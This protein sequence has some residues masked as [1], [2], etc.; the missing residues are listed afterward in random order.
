MRTEFSPPNLA[1][2]RAGS[3]SILSPSISRRLRIRS[4]LEG[5]TE[6]VDQSMFA[7]RVPISITHKR[8]GAVAIEETLFLARPLDWS[9]EVKGGDLKGRDSRPLPRQYLLMTEYTNNGDKPV[10]IT[11]LLDVQG[12]APGINLSDSSR[13]QVAPNTPCWTTLAI[14]P[15]GGKS[16]KTFTLGLRAPHHSAGRKGAMG[17]FDRSGWFQKR[18]TRGLGRSGRAPQARHRL[19]GKFDRAA[20]Q[21]DRN[22]RPA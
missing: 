5:S 17:P 6:R 21:R 19:L 20:L 10:E 12:S 3:A 11:P 7:P 8:Q 22:S 15:L 16:L 14:N 2:H 4:Y 18:Q 9:A 13:F 1:R